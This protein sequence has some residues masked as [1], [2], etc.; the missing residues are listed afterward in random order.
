MN[1]LRTVYR[2]RPAKTAKGAWI[3]KPNAR[4]G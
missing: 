1:G 4:C 2:E 3:V